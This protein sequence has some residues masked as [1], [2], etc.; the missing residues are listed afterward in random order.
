MNAAKPAKA[1]TPG[2]F[3]GAAPL[4]ARG[5]EELGEEVS[6]GYSGCPSVA[7]VMSGAPG[8]VVLAGVT[9]GVLSISGVV[10][11]ASTSGDVVPLSISFSKEVLTTGVE[12]AGVSTSVSVSFS[13]GGV[14]ITV[15]GVSEIVVA[16][17]IGV[18]AGVSTS[19]S[20]SFSGGEVRMIVVGVVI[21]KVVIE[22][23]VTVKVC[24]IGTVLGVWL[25][26]MTVLVTGQVVVV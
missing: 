16:I 12:G 4:K 17:V 15:V 19:V 11:V 20:V 14:L 24:V 13:G 5:E 7:S 10:V 6:T 18:V 23:V 25:I 9:C 3:V 22:L 2:L 1:A 8:T 26:V 21:G